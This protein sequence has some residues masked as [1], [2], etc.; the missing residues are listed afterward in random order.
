M[1][2]DPRDGGFASRKFWVV[3]GTATSIITCWL[4]T[5]FMKALVPTYDTVVG[6]LLAVAGLYL[7]GNVVTKW[8]TAKSNPTVTIKGDPG[9]GT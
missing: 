2:M 3:V 6:G 8:V 5:G 4:L 7:T 1:E 9:P